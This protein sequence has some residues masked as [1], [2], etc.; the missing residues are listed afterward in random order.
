MSKN[1]IF[2]PTWGKG[3]AVLGVVVFG[4]LAAV[5]Y[6]QTTSKLI[7]AGETVDLKTVQQAVEKEGKMKEKA[8]HAMKHG[9]PDIKAVAALPDGTVYF[10]GKLGL[11]RTKDGKAEEL[12][13]FPGED[14]KSIV[15][16]P[17]GEVLVAAKQG[18]WSSKDGAEWQQVLK[19][20]AH[21]LSVAGDG[22]IYAAVKEE[23]VMRRAAGSTDWQP[24]KLGLD[25][26]K[27]MAKAK[28]YEAKKEAEKAMK[29][30]KEEKEGKKPEHKD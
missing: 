21:G 12:T 8:D 15:A 22:A 30:E 27:L 16:T 7:A 26:Q 2:V 18:V 28:D 6:F 5:P 10:G 1:S 24:V 11:Y 23:G 17:A 4:A 29:K 20:D 19:G 14:P 9:K 3:A 13:K 25:E